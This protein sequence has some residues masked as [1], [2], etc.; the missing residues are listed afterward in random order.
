MELLG[1]KRIR[2][3]AYHPRANGL[4][5]RFHRQ[6]KKSLKVQFQSTL[7]VDALPLVLLG[8]RTALK[9]DIHCS[10]AKLVYSTTLRLSGEFFDSDPSLSL[11]DPAEY[12]TQLKATMAKLRAPPVCKPS[13]KKSYL[14]NDLSSCTHVYIRHDGTRKPHMRVC[15]KY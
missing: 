6:L 15:T 14:S 11:A 10:A 5:K 3:T 13:P 7:W 12:V 4:I 2:T 8:I 9:E 1:S